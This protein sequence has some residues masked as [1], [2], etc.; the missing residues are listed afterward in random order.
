MWR[1]I[2]AS[3]T[4]PSHAKTG[5]PC[6]DSH[7]VRA[8]G[9]GL[10][11][12]CVADGAGSSR[13]SEVGSAIAC[14][15]IVERATQWAQDHGSFGELSRDDF[16]GWCR[17]ARERIRDVATEHEAEPRDYATTLCVALLSPG[18]AALAQIGDGAIIGQRSGA[19]GVVF[20]PQS[21]EYVNTTMFLTGEDYEDHLQ[22]QSVAG[23]FEAVALMTDGVE[24]VALAFDTRTP[25]APFFQPLFAA[26]RGS[27]DPPS[28]NDELR[29]FLDSPSMHARS[30][31]DKTVV[32]ATQPAV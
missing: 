27:S 29:K 8:L 28:L 7:L 12:C 15:T 30:D 6:Q 5:A 1:H 19:L 14:D 4:G 25:H 22:F 20:W 2:Q 16:L 23:A 9:Q 31:D 11:V 26:L 21:G 18:G 32:L 10:L 13:H 24:R 17:R 3:V